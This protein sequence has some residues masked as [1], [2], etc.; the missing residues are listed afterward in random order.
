LKNP[1]PS[2]LRKRQNPTQK[3]SQLRNR[4][5]GQSSLL[6]Q[7]DGCDGYWKF[8]GLDVHIRLGAGGLG[9]MS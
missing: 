3:L 1:S 7:V 4:N 8:A 5:R 9:F 6:T 2:K